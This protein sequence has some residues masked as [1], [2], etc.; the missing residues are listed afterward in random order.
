MKNLILS[1]AL[2]A[3]VSTT[4]FL[5][6]PAH[7]EDIPFKPYIG[8]D[9]QHTSVDYNNNY[10]IGGGLALDG[11]TILE[12]GFNGANIHI[13]SRFHK[14]FGAELG[15]FRTQSES[16]DT[17]SGATVGP[18]TVATADFSTD[19]KLQGFTLDALGY[20]PI[21][22]EE[23]FELIGTA[24]VSWI[25]GEVEATVPGVGSAD[26]DDSE[27]GFRLGAGAQ[28]NVTDNI[29]L[30]GLVRYQ[31]VDFDNI[32]DNAWTYSLGVNYSF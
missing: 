3:G 11:E 24:G 21:D 18:S 6:S 4:A 26:V 13:G 32:A 2:I 9:L 29:D 23:R 5:I 7:A 14:Y 27:I 19:V 17:A 15:Y 31:K 1:T 25:K 16:K 22:K 12:D 10:D 8:L 28:Y 30:R 20:L